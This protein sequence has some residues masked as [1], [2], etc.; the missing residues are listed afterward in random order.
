MQCLGFK[1]GNGT[2]SRLLPKQDGS[3]YTLGCFVQSN[4]GAY[5]D[6]TIGGLKIGETLTRE[7]FHGDAKQ[8]AEVSHE[9]QTS[10]DLGSEGS[11]L[12][13]LATDAPLMPRTL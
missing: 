1:G 11:I 2:S 13:I 12:M 7:G 8:K 3:S 10:A 5:R 6:L 9:K 4:F